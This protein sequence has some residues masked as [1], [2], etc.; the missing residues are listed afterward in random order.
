[1]SGIV[2]PKHD[3][4]EKKIENQNQKVKS[5]ADCLENVLHVLR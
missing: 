3:E 4:F 1:M 2:K 5:I